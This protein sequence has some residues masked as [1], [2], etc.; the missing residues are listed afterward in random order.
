MPGT[1]RRIANRLTIEGLVLAAT[2][3]AACSIGTA[4]PLVMAKYEAGN[5]STSW[6][7]QY[8][9]GWLSSWGEAWPVD[10]YGYS[11][12]GPAAGGQ[13]AW[14]IADAT[15]GGVD[16]NYFFDLPAVTPL[17]NNPYYER[18]LADGWRLH[19]NAQFVSTM[20]GSANQGL[21][22]FFDNRV[23]QVMIDHDPT[24][25]LR[26]QVYTAPGSTANYVLQDAA[27]A[28]A[29]YD[30]ELRYHPTTQKVSFIYEG[31]SLHTWAGVA[32]SHENVFR[33]GALTSTGRGKMNYRS[34]L[35]ELLDPAPTPVELG[36]Y[37]GD[38]QVNLSDYTVWRQLLG[39]NSPLADGNG[40]G[41]VTALD[42]EVWKRNFGATLADPLS[43]SAVLPEP[44]SCLL[45]SVAAIAC[46][47]AQQSK[48]AGMRKSHAG[49]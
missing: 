7:P 31:T 13:N 36:D 44:A 1:N 23:Y 6:S 32:A 20:N 26:A 17:G 49:P 15:A 28:G 40:D 46:F 24:G 27:A 39:S 38:G 14:Q 35:A 4:A 33:F 43:T 37:D 11:V 22:V 16:P 12:T 47:V 34:V 30:Y 21:S 25:N 10:P 3:V 8:H 29:Y 41:Q 19:T 2:L 18:A 45:A 48:R 9:W 42:Y 5:A